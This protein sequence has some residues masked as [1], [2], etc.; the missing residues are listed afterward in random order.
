MMSTA[1]YLPG[2]VAQ[3]IPPTALPTAA[4]SSRCRS[5][6]IMNVLEGI[7]GNPVDALVINIKL[8]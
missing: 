6:K 4:L 7:K 5:D 8:Y 1:Q 3:N 2:N